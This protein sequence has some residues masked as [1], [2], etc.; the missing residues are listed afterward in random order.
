M[1]PRVLWLSSTFAAAK[2]AMALW[3]AQLAVSWLDRRRA[4][5]GWQIALSVLAILVSW[6]AMPTGGT[7]SWWRP[8]WMCNAILSAAVL[9][10]CVRRWMSVVEGDPQ[11]ARVHAGLAWIG[12]CLSSV[13]TAVAVIQQLPGDWW[14]Q[15]AAVLTIVSCAGLLGI[16]IAASL[17]L[18]L[19][20]LG[21]GLLNLR[22]P[23]LAR[24]ASLWWA[25][26]I[27]LSGLILLKRR[28]VESPLETATPFLFAFGMIIVGYIAWCIPR[29]MVALSKRQEMQGQVS[30][31]IAAW[32][33]TLCLLIACGL[34]PAWP[35]NQLEDNSQ[36]ALRH[37]RS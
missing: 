11:R 18:T 22:W 37:L 28:A 29:Q 9:F 26:Q 12:L 25:I 27:A 5:L 6:W 16:S 31:A 8:A 32:L 21:A 23:V 15:A 10:D 24:W 2:F 17:E 35:W 30:L 13:T 7:Q 34:P 1:D 36:P 14:T 20:A 4:T 3:S 33:A 19:G